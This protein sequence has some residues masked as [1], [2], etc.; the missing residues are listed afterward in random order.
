MYGVYI[1]ME[2]KELKEKIDSNNLADDFMVWELT[3]Y[4]SEVIAKQYYH[5]IA[6]QKN[7]EIKLIDN[8]DEIAV[9]DG[10]V[11]DD[12]LYVYKTDKLE[13]FKLHDNL[14]IICKKTSYKD[15]IKIPKLEP[16]QFI[17]YLQYKLP[18]MNK[19]DLEWLI[20]QYEVLDSR[21]KEIKY[22]RLENDLDKIAIFEPSL[23]DSVFN[24]LYASGEYSTI[25]NLTV[26]DLSEALIKRDSKLALEVLKV[27]DY[28]DSKPHVWILSILL[29]NFRNIIGVQIGDNKAEELGISDKQLYVVK[30]YNCGFYSTKQLYNIY[31]VLTDVEYMYKFGGLD[32][33]Y[34][35]DYLC[36]KILGE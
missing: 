29:N 1:G 10:F 7:L 6:E 34:L 28:I 35:T 25:S 14:I 17:D 30:K 3:D 8:F 20:T 32:M 22:E 18:G 24:E 27:F 15:K 4:S 5:K 23:Q 2:I 21:V 31:K 36:C 26:F 19:S 11:V 9:E 12:N 13:D 33:D 16:W